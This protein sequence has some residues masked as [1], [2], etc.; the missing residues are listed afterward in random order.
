MLLHNPSN[1]HI[2]S[3]SSFLLMNNILINE[4]RL[5]IRGF[6]HIP[7]R[8]S[9]RAPWYTSSR[10]RTFF[11]LICRCFCFSSPTTA[12]WTTST[13]ILVS[14]SNFTK[15]WIAVKVVNGCEFY[16]QTSC[17]F[18]QITSMSILLIVG[19][20]VQMHSD[21]IACSPLISHVDCVE[22]N[23]THSI[24]VR[25]KQISSMRD[26]RSTLHNWRFAKFKVMWHEN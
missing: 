13:H 10:F 26:W 23:T 20:N 16:L 24:K 25:K 7:I 8:I 5:L 6:T 14:C 17:S 19:P 18:L 1:A 4:S 9:S 2:I 12:S 21:C 15:L 22:C 11:S 3:T